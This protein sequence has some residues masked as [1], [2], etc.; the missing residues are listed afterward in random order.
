MSSEYMA[1]MG[2]KKQMVKQMINLKR[3]KNKEE[4]KESLE[5]QNK[6]ENIS[7]EDRKERIERLKAIGL[8]K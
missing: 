2:R 6:D 4:G 8:I 5:K 1:I 3:A 7:K